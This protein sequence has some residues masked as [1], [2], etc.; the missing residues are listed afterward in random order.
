[1]SHQHFEMPQALHAAYKHA[2]SQ[3]FYPL[4]TVRCSGDVMFRTQGARDLGCLLDVDDDIVAWLCLPI[5]FPTCDGVHV[6]DFMVDYRNGRREFLDA[7]D[8][9][10][11]AAVSEGAACSHIHHR[12][13]SRGEIEEGWRLANAKDML[14]YAHYRTP[15]N[16]RLRM[17]AVL[18]EVGSMAI[19]DC[20]NLFREVQPMTGI[21]W[22]I[23]NRLISVDL[24]ERMLGPETVLRRFVAGGPR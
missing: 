21:S 16:D 24:D 9:D 8:L 23:L 22:M 11:D 15:L 14:R 10:G 6:P 2:I 4:G 19:G 3:K 7:C 5:E 12:F 18:D 13:I 20:M 17:L 1:M